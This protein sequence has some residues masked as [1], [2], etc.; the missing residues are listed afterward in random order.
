MY[1]REDSITLI[2]MMEDIPTLPESFLRIKSLLARDDTNASDLAKAIR[3][4]HA[5]SACVLKVANSAY[6]NSMGRPIAVLSQ[7]I[8]RLG[9]VEASHIIMA[10]SLLYG[11]SLPLGMNYIRALWAHAFAV[12]V[13]CE[14]L[15]KRH[16]QDPEE[17]FMAGLLHDVGRAIIGMRLDLTYFESSMASLD[18]EALIEE[19]VKKYG[20]DHAEAGAIIL[21]QW[22]FPA[23]LQRTVAEHHDLES[24]FLPA[25]ICALA[26]EEANRRFAFG[27][28]IDQISALLAEDSLEDLPEL[29][30]LAANMRKDSDNKVEYVPLNQAAIV[31][32]CIPRAEAA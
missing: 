6:Y 16:N 27:S 11:F 2:Q 4:D 19:E 31:L 15:A 17:L 7:A 14:R 28:N 30:P 5:I 21:R 25:R 32:P 23:Y 29:P 13:L 10:S 24:T 8:A 20:L 9:F 3:T 26:D 12:G 18:D 1:C 22:D